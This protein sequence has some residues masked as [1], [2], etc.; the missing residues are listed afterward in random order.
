MIQRLSLGRCNGIPFE[1]EFEYGG[2]ADKTGVMM[3]P[4]YVDLASIPLPD[5]HSH[6]SYHLARAHD[7]YQHAE[8]QD[9]VYRAPARPEVLEYGKGEEGD[10][11]DTPDPF[12]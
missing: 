11:Y 10:T 6:R 9:W 1:A 3:A 5:L 4:S 8:Y 7:H 2:R 12:R